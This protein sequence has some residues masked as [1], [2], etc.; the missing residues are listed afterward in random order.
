M[1]RR[2]RS[3]KRRSPLLPARWSCRPAAAAAGRRTPAGDV[4]LDTRD[5]IGERVR[6][7]RRH[8]PKGCSR[9]L[10][11]LD[12]GP[13]DRLP[14]VYD[15]ALN[16]SS[17]GDGRVDVES[18]GSF[19]AAYQPVTPLTLGE[20]WASPNLLRP[21]LSENVRQANRGK[22]KEGVRSGRSRWSPSL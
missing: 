18:L 4:R 1:L 20:L 11:R 6:L 15:I 14:R 17:H 9:E 8:L 16:A 10:P 22:G 21:A 19:I 2:P 13:S 5:R 3:S 7:A 12:G